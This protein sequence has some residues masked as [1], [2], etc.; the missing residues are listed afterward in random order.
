MSLGDCPLCWGTIYTCTCWNDE[1][2]EASQKRLDEMDAASEGLT[3]E[4][5]YSRKEKVEINFKIMECWDEAL[6]ENKR[7]DEM[8]LYRRLWSVESVPLI[9]DRV[10]EKKEEK[11]YEDRKLGSGKILGFGNLQFVSKIIK[12]IKRKIKYE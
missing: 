1:N 11:I 2:R 5:F 6:E 9:A 7:F 12:G 4:Q 8:L 10:R 3:L